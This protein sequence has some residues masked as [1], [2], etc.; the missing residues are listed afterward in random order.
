MMAKAE[1]D[2]KQQEIDSQFD[3]KSREADTNKLRLERNAKREA[4]TQAKI[5]QRKKWT[6]L[7]PSASK[8]YFLR[9]NLV[10][11]AFA[12]KTSEAAV[13]LGFKQAGKAEVDTSSGIQL[14]GSK[15]ETEGKSRANKHFCFLF[16][17][18]S[19]REEWRIGLEPQL[20]EMERGSDKGK[21]R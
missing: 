16:P 9:K 21:K 17:S 6:K 15:G 1:F 2:K 12:K 14:F 19:S 10:E 20:V 8:I 7:L 5:A 13:Y 3:K 18:D 11:A 4:L